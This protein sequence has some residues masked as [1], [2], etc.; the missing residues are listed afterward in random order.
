TGAGCRMRCSA[1]RFAQLTGV[2]VKALRHYEHRGLLTPQRTAAGYRRYSLVDLQRLEE[3]L[4]L[5]SLGLPLSPVARVSGGADSEA[6]RAQRARLVEARARL[7]RAID[8]LDAVAD[9]PDPARALRR[10]VMTSSWE[11]F[12]ARREAAG[13][14][15]ARPPDR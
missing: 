15:T 4:A 14:G 8:A 6:P 2:T 1:R 3:I 7:D 9:D 10:F 5:K 13:R 12:E 11:R